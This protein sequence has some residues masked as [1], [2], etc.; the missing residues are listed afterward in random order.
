VREY[1]R[2]YRTS[3]EPSRANWDSDQPRECAGCGEKLRITKDSI[4]M[5][6]HPRRE[7]FHA[8]CFRG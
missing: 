3:A 2:T 1:T 5:R 4:V 8:R 7:S 6:R